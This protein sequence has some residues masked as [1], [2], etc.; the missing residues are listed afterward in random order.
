MVETLGN[1]NPTKDGSFME[2]SHPYFFKN[3]IYIIINK[4]MK[5]STTYTSI[6]QPIN[7]NWCSR[8]VCL[9]ED[10]ILG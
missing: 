3:Y 10:I 1:N 6:L 4:E 7:H 9:G 8:R 2:Y 5:T